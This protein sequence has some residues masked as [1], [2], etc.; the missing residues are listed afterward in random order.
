ML[1]ISRELGM[2]GNSSAAA[3]NGNPILRAIQRWQP[4][5]LLM[6]VNWMD[7]FTIIDEQGVL[8]K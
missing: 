3:S 8:R 4:A 7:V 6:V 5:W 1:C 2:A